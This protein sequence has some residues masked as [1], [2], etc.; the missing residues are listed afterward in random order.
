MLR[1]LACTATAVR[2]LAG[3]WIGTARGDA[4]TPHVADRVY[5]AHPWAP[6]GRRL[7]LDAA[8][9]IGQILDVPHGRGLRVEAMLLQE[10]RGIAGTR[11][12]GAPSA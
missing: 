12:G 9:R 4:R 2:A 10:R 6:V 7:A 5:D 11:T 8:A 1:V 3:A